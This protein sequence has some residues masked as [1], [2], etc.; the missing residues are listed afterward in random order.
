MLCIITLQIKLQFFCLV[1]KESQVSY[2]QREVLFLLQVFL[3]SSSSNSSQASLAIYET[4][5][6]KVSKHSIK[7]MC[8]EEKFIIRVC[9]LESECLFVLITIHFSLF[10]KSQNLNF[11]SQKKGKR[12]IHKAGLKANIASMEIGC[13]A[14][15]ARNNICNAKP[16]QNQ[17]CKA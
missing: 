5:R 15:P 14:K 13:I 16:T 6:R 8:K 2:L 4:R 17:A 7:V 9:V 1:Y 11:S 12:S 3:A 10:C